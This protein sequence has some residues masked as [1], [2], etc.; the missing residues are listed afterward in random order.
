MG[1]HVVSIPFRV[2]HWDRL[3]N[4][5]GQMDAY[6]QQRL[7]QDPQRPWVMW[8]RQELLP[9]SLKGLGIGPL[10]LGHVRPPQ[11]L[12]PSD[13]APTSVCVCFVISFISHPTAA[14]LAED[15][16]C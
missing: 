10:G 8:H 15:S 14:R 9:S 7:L 4:R 16:D 12:H 6:V 1:R 11:P 2:F 3:H 13:P 5:P